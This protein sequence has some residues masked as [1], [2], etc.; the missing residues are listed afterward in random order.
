MLS[1]TFTIPR[2]KDLDEK[3]LGK[4]DTERGAT[5]GQSSVDV[6]SRPKLKITSVRKDT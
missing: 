2:T 3:V 6:C 1:L 4:E 5:R